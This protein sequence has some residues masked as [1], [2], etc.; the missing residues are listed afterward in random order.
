M[1]D[2]IVFDRKPYTISW[3]DDKGDIQKIRR[4]PPAK[5]HEGLPTDVVELTRARSDDFKEGDK[6]T[7]KNINPRHPNTLQLV[8]EEGLTTFVSYRDVVLKE[9]LALRD[10]MRPEELPERNRYLNWP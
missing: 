9:K 6:A 7:I 5:L 3:K 4:V 8:N 2:P 1:A 10:G